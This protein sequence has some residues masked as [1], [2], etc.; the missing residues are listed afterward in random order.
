IDAGTGPRGAGFVCAAVRSLLVTGAWYRG[1]RR[2]LALRHRPDGIVLV[3]EPGRTLGRGEI[4]QSIGAP[5]VASVSTDPAIARA[6]DAG[7]LASRLPRVLARELRGA[8]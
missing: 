4:E 3:A 1:L 6:V 7:L 8:A 2:G 5:I